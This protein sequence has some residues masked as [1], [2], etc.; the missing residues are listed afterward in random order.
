MRAVLLL[1]LAFA[2]CASAASRDERDVV[3]QVTQDACTA[4]RTGDLAAM[5]RLLAADFTLVSSTSRVQSRAETIAEIKAGDTQYAEFRNHDMTAHVYRDAAIVQGI[6]SL[7]GTSG[8]QTFAVDV[9]FT[10]TLIREHGRWRIV[11]SHVTR[12]P[13]PANAKP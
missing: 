13:P 7:A 2:T 3:M 8:G 6:T 4:F 11:V 12:I 5:E 9:R 1:L 10:D